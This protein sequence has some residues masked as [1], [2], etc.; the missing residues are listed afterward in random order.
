MT[1]ADIIKIRKI[2]KMTQAQ[3]AHHMG[4]VT[5]TIWG[6]EKGVRKPHPYLL[7]KLQKMKEEL[8]Q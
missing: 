5:T 6:W 3:F 7:N 2:L 1:P 8:I 4:V